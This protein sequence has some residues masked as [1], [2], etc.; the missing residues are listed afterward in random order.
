MKRFK[1]CMQRCI[2]PCTH[3]HPFAARP[4][5]RIGD[6]NIQGPECNRHDLSEAVQIE[7]ARDRQLAGRHL[8]W[9]KSAAGV[10]LA[11]GYDYT[12]RRLCGH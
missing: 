11:K 5:V 10:F 7:M 1:A 2:S 12:D 9:P 4:L 8:T 6:R 3:T